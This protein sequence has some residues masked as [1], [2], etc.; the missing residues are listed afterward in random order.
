MSRWIRYGIP[1]ALLLLS[2]ILY[3]CGWFFLW[4]WVLGVVLLIFA[5][6]PDRL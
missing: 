1:I 4:G 6:L 5:D 2:T 3:F